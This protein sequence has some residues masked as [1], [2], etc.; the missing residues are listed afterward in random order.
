MGKEIENMEQLVNIIMAMKGPRKQGDVPLQPGVSLAT[1]F[2]KATVRL[3]DYEI[4]S[5]DPTVNKLESKFAS[6]IPL[7]EV[8]Q[9][10]L[11]S[12]REMYRRALAVTSLNSGGI[13]TLK[14]ENTTYWL[15]EGESPANDPNIPNQKWKVVATVSFELPGDREHELEIS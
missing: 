4:V 9:Q 13:Q 6:K 3:I 1:P 7:A 11:G 15:L 8:I 14:A 5:D 12:Y 2:G 10:T